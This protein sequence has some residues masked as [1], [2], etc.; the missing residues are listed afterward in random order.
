M[1]FKYLIIAFSIIIV[2]I[3]LILALSLLLVA[4][5]ESTANLRYITLSVFLFMALIL[6]CLGIFFLFN[7]RLFSLL[8]REDWPALA[9]YLEQKIYVKG[10][11]SV[12]NVRILAGSYMVVSD[13]PSVLKLESKTMLVKPD[14]IK[15]NA[16]IF[17][18]A[19]VLNGS[20]K[21][22]AAF[23]KTYLGKDEWVRW[24][25]NF[26]LLLDGAFS[27]V[28]PE[29]L[30][31]AR[32]SGNVLITGLSAFFLTNN[33]ARHSQ[34]P[35]ECRA[36]SESGRSRV[37]DLLKKEDNWKKEADKMRTEIHIAIIRKYI[38]EV[39][40]WLFAS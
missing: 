13:Y 10:R 12:Q 30:S 22:A 20:Y 15:K 23:F 35:E 6:V 3:L 8:E 21:E 24:F 2:F 39:G 29:F 18:S 26:S 27:Q 31:L 33:L 16:L 11:Y 4:K 1:K 17:G 34:N 28:E 7:Y 25:Y 9:Y 19:R 5:Y 40:K 36:V 32:Y 14:I 38:D 37:V